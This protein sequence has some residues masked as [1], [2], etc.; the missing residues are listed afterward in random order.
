MEYTWKLKSLKKTSVGDLSDFI[1]QT[2]WE[3]IGVDDDG[4]S[5]SFNGA[6]PFPQD[7][8]DT[9]NFIPFNELTEEI[10]L[11]WIQAQVVDSYEEHVNAQIQRQIDEQ[12]VKIDDVQDGDFPWSPP[13]EEEDAPPT[14]TTTAPSSEEDSEV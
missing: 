13:K 10:V 1:F 9:E 4:V 11:G 6:T 7:P 14:I 5:G 12:K 8:T 3:K 2:H